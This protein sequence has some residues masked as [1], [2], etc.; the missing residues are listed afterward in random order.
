MGAKSKA[1]KR[2]VDFHTSIN[3]ANVK[4]LLEFYDVPNSRKFFTEINVSA[5]GV[6]KN[7]IHKLQIPTNSNCPIKV[8]IYRNRILY[9]FCLLLCMS[10]KLSLTL[11]EE[12]DAE[13]H[14][15]A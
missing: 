8:K 13:K 2:G 1:D 12:R 3:Q 9:N 10:V 4:A 15:R 11:R 6:C 7:V 14:I 5:Q